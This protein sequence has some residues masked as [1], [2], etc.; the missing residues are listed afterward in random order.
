M[1]SFLFFFGW[2]ELVGHSGCG[3]V[4]SGRKYGGVRKVEFHSFCKFE[5]GFELFFGFSGES[6]D[7]VGGEGAVGDFFPEIFD[8]AFVFFDGVVSV[9]F[10]KH[11]VGSVLHGEVYVRAASFGFGDGVDDVVGEVLWMSRGKSYP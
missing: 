11:G 1:K 5:K 7:Y 8:D 9:H 6:D 10:P 4:F 2:Y 3:S